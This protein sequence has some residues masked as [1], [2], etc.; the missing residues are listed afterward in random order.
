MENLLRVITL[1]KKYPYIPS[2]PPLKRFLKAIP[3]LGTPDK[4]RVKDMP[5]MGFKSSNARYIPSILKFIGFIE[6]SG[7]PTE[8][9][10]NFKKIG[11]SKSVIASALKKTYE[12]LFKLYP[13]APK[14]EFQ[15]LRDFFSGTTD[16]GERVLKMTVDTFKTLCEFADFEAAPRK[17]I[18]E[19]TKENGERDE[20]KPPQ[21]PAGVTIN[22]NIQLTLPA[23]EDAK[24]YENIF[25]ALKDNLL[26]R[27]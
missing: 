2:Q 24:V 23:T 21:M 15:P 18:K 4:I 17:K 16:A 20:E 22:L 6:Q 7:I 26:S 1:A 8:D 25:K 9:Y 10:K 13:D 11:I 27:D 19:D 5:Q 3:K 14:K 12:D